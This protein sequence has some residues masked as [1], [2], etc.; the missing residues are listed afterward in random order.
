MEPYANNPE[1]LAAYPRYD[2]AMAGSFTKVV[3]SI[4][5]RICKNPTIMEIIRE[6]APAYFDGSKSAEDVS[7]IIQSRASTLIAEM[8]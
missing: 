5:R 1:Y 4:S 6:E 8:G 3:E 7:R 2:Q